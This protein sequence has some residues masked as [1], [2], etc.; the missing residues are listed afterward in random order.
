MQWY[1]R[2]NISNKDGIVCLHCMLWVKDMA[3]V[4]CVL[5]WAADKPFE[6]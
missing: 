5:N 1:C 6:I 4:K 3:I 2:C